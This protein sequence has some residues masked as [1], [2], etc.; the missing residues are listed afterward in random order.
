MKINK[1]PIVYII[2]LILL[3]AIFG[4]IKIMGVVLTPQVL[5]GCIIIFIG[6]T[7]ITVGI[8]IATI[9]AYKELQSELK[10]GVPLEVKKTVVE[11]LVEYQRLF[12]QMSTTVKPTGT[13]VEKVYTQITRLLKKVS[14][15]DKLLETTFSKTDLTY[16]TYKDS[17]NDVLKTF[18]ANVRGVKKR[19]DVFDYTS[20]NTD[21][22]NTV[23]KKY[24]KAI[25]MMV[26]QNAK[27]LDS[28]DNLISEL[29][30]IDDVSNFSLETIN[31]LIEQT[32]DYKT[33][34]KDD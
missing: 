16:I 33:V 24:I 14:D 20:W 26:S 32:Q 17:L 1:L 3:F 30:S 15:I 19:I 9:K 18:M 25:K 13:Y 4:V 21:D 6:L 29:V 7:G 22:E 34:M 10:N 28:M 2:Y 27:I 5:V 31:N 11:E 8:T 23:S 12:K